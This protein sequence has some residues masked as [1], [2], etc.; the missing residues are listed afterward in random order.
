[1]DNGEYYA[2]KLFSLETL[3]QLNLEE[4]LE[5]VKKLAHRHLTRVM[6][7]PSEFVY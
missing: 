1:M 3:K 5:I 2:I 7:E 4:G 6:D